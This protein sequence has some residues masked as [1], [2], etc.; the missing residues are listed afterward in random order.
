M[1]IQKKLEIKS[2]IE[3][4]FR[5]VVLIREIKKAIKNNDLAYFINNISFTLIFY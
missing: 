1:K 5:D 2:L 4:D 3:D